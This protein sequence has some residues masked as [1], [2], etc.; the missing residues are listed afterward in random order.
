MSDLKII[1]L[2]REYPNRKI[3]KPEK[4]NSFLWLDNENLLYSIS[5]DGIYLYNCKQNITSKVI[6]GNEKFELYEVENNV[7]K[8]DDKQIRITM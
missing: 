1:S 8:Y 5:Y 4:I 7:V 3:D 6:D 2:N